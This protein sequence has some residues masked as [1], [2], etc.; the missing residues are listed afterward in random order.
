MERYK[1]HFTAEPP[2]PDRVVVQRSNPKRIN[3]EM[4]MKPREI[5]MLASVCLAVMCCVGCT[6]QESGIR[7]QTASAGNQAAQG[8]T[9]SKT[10]RVVKLRGMLK[11]HDGKRL[12]GVVGVLFAIYEQ[13]EGGPPLWQ[14]VQN[15]D[16]DN[17][18]RFT[19]LVGAT[20]SEGIPPELF[21]TEKTRWLGKQVLLPGEVEQS[22]IQ[23]VSTSEGLVTQRVVTLV[24]P[25]ESGD[26]PA[27][28][29]AQQASEQA[30]DSPKDES[31]NRPSGS[32]LRLHR[33]R[34]T[35]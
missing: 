12:T 23:L 20:K 30:A 29:E 11:D 7:P 14:E 4:G 8:K 19:A 18:G 6:Q 24:I 27:T 26:P 16:V 15:V 1:A 10:S 33:R 13:Q 25:E 34:L 5:G 22:R 35:P 32:R 31:V 2:L 17:H 21:T 28:A 9:D 3:E